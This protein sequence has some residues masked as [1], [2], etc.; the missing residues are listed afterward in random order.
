MKIRV[1]SHQ[2]PKDPV[3][4]QPFLVFETVYFFA[5]SYGT[6]VE[7]DLRS[8][9]YKIFKLF[10]TLKGHLNFH[11]GYFFLPEQFGI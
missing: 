4:R 6:L 7:T 9:R 3:H 1:L 11:T 2:G 5:G 10:K 8:A